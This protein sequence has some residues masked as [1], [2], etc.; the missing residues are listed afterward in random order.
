[1][2]IANTR[3]FHLFNIARIPFIRFC[4]SQRHSI[5]GISL[6]ALPLVFLFFTDWRWALFKFPVY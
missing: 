1:M 5:Y 3:E 4:L 2:S 6:F